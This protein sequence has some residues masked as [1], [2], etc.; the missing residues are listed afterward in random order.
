MHYYMAPLESVTTYIYRNAQAKV[1]G[2]LDKYFIPFLEPHEKRDF[3]KREMQEIL[4]EHNRGLYAV[5][6]ILTNKAEGFGRLARA[7]GE[8]GYGELNLNLGCPSKTVVSKGKGSGFLAFPEELDRFLDRI[9]QETEQEISI[10]TRI[11]RESPEEFGRLLAIYNRYPLKELIIHPRV[12]RDFYNH[13][14]NREVYRMA[15][16]E[17]RN[18]LCY[19][20]DLFCREDVEQFCMEFPE[21][22]TIMLGRGLLQDPGMAGPSSTME[23]FREFHEAVYQGYRER[24]QG[25]RNVLFKMK[26]LWSYQILRFPGAEAYGKRIRKTQNCREYEQIVRELLADG[27]CHPAAL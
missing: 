15:V 10:K 12:Q 25:D 22:E 19:N 24:E 27:S 23:Q 1:Y 3:K 11:G 2:P 6:Q 18:P 14:P 16:S 13:T 20:G 8:F 21:T 17:S 9:F 26:E 5:P 7:L 4:P